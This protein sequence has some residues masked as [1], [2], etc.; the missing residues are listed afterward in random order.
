MAHFE[1]EAIWAGTSAQSI[2]GCAMYSCVFSAWLA[3]D[4]AAKLGSGFASVRR[5]AVFC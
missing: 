2:T 3:Q 5:G 4:R 1:N